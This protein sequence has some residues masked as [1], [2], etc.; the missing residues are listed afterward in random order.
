MCVF[1]RGFQA[2]PWCPSL[3]R[4]WGVHHEC[5]RSWAAQEGVMHLPS[6]NESFKGVPDFY[7]EGIM[8]SFCEIKFVFKCCYCFSR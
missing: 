6:W 4:S 3:H 2:A 7:L 8:L 5:R 1:S